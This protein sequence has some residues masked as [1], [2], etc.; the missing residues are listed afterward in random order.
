MSHCWGL[1]RSFRRAGAAGEELKEEA[2]D[3][4]L[5]VLSAGNMV[6]LLERL[7]LRLRTRPAQIA[8]GTLLPGF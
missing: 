1:C 6:F 3:K 4:L 7:L 5:E 2:L 8:I